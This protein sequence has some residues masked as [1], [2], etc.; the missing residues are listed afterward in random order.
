[1]DQFYLRRPSSELPKDV[2]KDRFGALDQEETLKIIRE[3]LKELLLSDDEI[4]G[5]IRDAPDPA[6]HTIVPERQIMTSITTDQL[7]R[8]EY[9]TGL[10]RGPRWEQLSGKYIAVDCGESPQVFRS[11]ET[12]EACAT[13]PGFNE[14]ACEIRNAAPALI[15]AAREQLRQDED[16]GYWQFPGT[17]PRPGGKIDDLSRLHAQVSSLEKELDQARTLV[18]ELV[19]SL[20]SV[21]NE[22]VPSHRLC[23]R[24]LVPKHPTVAHAQELIARSEKA[25][26]G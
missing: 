16:G 4:R 26:V 19:G 20:R 8:I 14:W 12:D 17:K 15:A 3:I 10:L 1:M 7:D 9:L 13:R 5:K 25:G 6:H 23:D 2:W 18:G 24:G 22:C 11:P 21:L